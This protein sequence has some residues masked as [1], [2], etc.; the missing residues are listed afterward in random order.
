SSPRHTFSSLPRGKHSVVF[1]A[2]TSPARQSRATTIEVLYDRQAPTARVSS[3][4]LEFADGESVTLS[5]QALSGWEVSV[6][7][8]QV[9]VDEQQ[10]FSVEVAGRKSIPITF[11]HPDKGTHYYLRRA[12]SKQ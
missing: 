1:S 3:P 7:G 10:R 8:D 4:S 9:N 6:D 12:K 2:A 11:T 5:G